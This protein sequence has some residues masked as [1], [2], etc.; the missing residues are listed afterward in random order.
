MKRWVIAVRPPSFSA[1]SLSLTTL[2]PQADHTATCTSLFSLELSFL[3]TVL[4][5]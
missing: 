4:T 2:V 3:P 5:R 1:L